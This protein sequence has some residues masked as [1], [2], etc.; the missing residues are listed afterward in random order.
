MSEL[1]NL[2]LIGIFLFG[3]FTI[4]MLIGYTI[5]YWITGTKLYQSYIRNKREKLV[6]RF[7]EGLKK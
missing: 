5:W 6:N 7:M 1:L 4:F 2:A 3:L